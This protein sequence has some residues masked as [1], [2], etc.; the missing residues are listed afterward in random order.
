MISNEAKNRIRDQSPLD[1]LIGEVTALE[2]RSGHLIGC[3]PFHEEK[4][5]SFHVFTDHYH[6]FGCGAHGDAIAFAQ[7][8]YGLAFVPAL[9]MLAEKFSIPL[10][11]FEDRTSYD[12]EQAA[13]Q[14]RV[15]L[16]QATQTFFVQNLTRDSAGYAILLQ[17]GFSEDA[18]VK[19]G[20]GFAPNAARGLI[21][22]LLDLKFSVAEI[23]SG[24]LLSQREGR[25]YD[26]FR[27][28]IMIPIRDFYGRAIAFAGRAI[29]DNPVKYINSRYDKSLNLFGLDE[30]KSAIR[31]KGRA[32]VA[33]G[34][35]DVLQLWQNG[36]EEAVAC[37]G[38]ALTRQQIDKLKLITKSV[39]LLFDGD[40]AGLKAT[41][42]TQEIAFDY[43]ELDFRVCR[44]PQGE[45]PDSFTRKS[46]APAFETLLASGQELVAF[47]I[48]QKLSNL[49]GSATPA[50][51]RDTL[52]PWIASMKD[53]IQQAFIIGKVA[54]H[55]GISADILHSFLRQQGT[56][57]SAAAKSAAAIVVEHVERKAEAFSVL[58]QIQ[59][60]Y[61][62]HLYF[63]SPDSPDLAAEFVEARL[64]IPNALSLPHPWDVVGLGLLDHLTLG[65]AP[66]SL[67]LDRWD[68]ALH[69]A[70]EEFTT[71]CQEHANAYAVANRAAS[72]AQLRA[73]T[74][75]KNVHHSLAALK[76]RAATLNPTND[77]DRIAWRDLLTTANQL[78]R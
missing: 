67:S 44:L 14:R 61:L 3:C 21:Q 1:R 43:P 8:H 5:P 49:G 70:L 52:M 45:D 60:E 63:A 26:F 20:F 15:A 6:C 46:G 65:H 58:T 55:S 23:E 48:D 4:T 57:T 31:T 33:E 59:K 40:S 76:A 68:T 41:L 24:S 25:T 29:D 38:T 28:R 50:L 12:A 7:N 32:I 75:R 62:A 34:Y 13:A 53:P 72:F 42:R 36:F 10:D 37:Q 39:Y 30:A 2:N 51:I 27:N 22:H 56:P 47:S 77:P 17:R 35:M 66:A 74:Q 78:F 69:Q 71:Y 9:K 73:L 11:E 18:I 16:F 64:F 19:Y 54:S